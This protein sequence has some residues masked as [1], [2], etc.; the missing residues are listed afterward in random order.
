MIIYVKSDRGGVLLL[1]FVFRC[2]CV[3]VCVKFA[4]PDS[5]SMIAMLDRFSVLIVFVR[6]TTTSPF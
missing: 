3:S 2:V 1:F 5:R 6:N 4:P